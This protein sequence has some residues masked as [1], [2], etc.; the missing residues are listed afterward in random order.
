DPE[1]DQAK[2]RRQLGGEEHPHHPGDG[3]QPAEKRR[4]R[5]RDRRDRQ[6]GDARRRRQEGRGRQGGRREDEERD[7]EGRRIVHTVR[8]ERGRH[9]QQRWRAA[10]DPNLRSRCPRAQG[11][12]LHEDNLAGPGGSL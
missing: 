7:A 1:R 5:R 3:R 8:R 2:G 12:G 4:H 6:G 10:R 11:Q 9:H